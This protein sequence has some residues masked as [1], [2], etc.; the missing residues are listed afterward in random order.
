MTDDL[1][2]LIQKFQQ[3]MLQEARNT[4]GD[5]FF[6]RW[7]NPLYRGRMAD[8][9]TTAWLKGSCGDSMQIYLQF[10][11]GRVKAA[12]FETDGCAPSIVCGSYAAELS[13][14]KDPEELLDISAQ[15]IIDQLGHLP[16]AV[17]HC[18]F[19]AAATIHHAVDNYMIQGIE[20]NRLQGT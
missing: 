9:D 3:E 20:K 11:N 19:L 8:A 2:T 13:I 14:D 10:K 12:S 6:R 18:A 5:V 15:T 4:Y 16:E 1:N 7:Q 17:Q